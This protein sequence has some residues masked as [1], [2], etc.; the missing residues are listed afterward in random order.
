MA[1]KILL[2]EGGDDRDFFMA[3]LKHSGL[4]DVN[5]ESKTPRQTDASIKRD[6]VDNL[7]NAFKLQLGRL[8]EEDGIERLGVVVDA[9]HATGDPSCDFGFGIR[10]N[11]VADILAALGWHPALTAL[12]K[13]ALF[14]HPDGL[15]DVG[16]WVMPDHGSDGMLEDFVTTLVTGAVQRELLTHAQHTV[17][18]LVTKLFDQKLHTTKANIGTWRAW[19]KPPGAPLG[20]LIAAG[21][22]DLTLS[23][24]VEFID[25]LKATFQ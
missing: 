6:G 21:T 2:V 18:H 7:L 4:T 13:G 20:K 17:N 16:L 25:W 1:G 11:Q 10:Q 9:D 8:K 12:S 5:I 15:P 23:P 3:V 19:Q 22:L 24:A 14:H